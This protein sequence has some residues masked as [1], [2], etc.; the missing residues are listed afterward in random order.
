MDDKQHAAFTNGE[1]KIARTIG[2]A[3]TTFDGWATGKTLELVPDKK[4]VQEWRASDWP[5]NSLSTITLE[6]SPVAEGT[7][8]QFTQINVPSS[9]AK[10]IAKGW[11]EFYWEPLQDFFHE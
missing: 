11:K 1:A 2:G 4:I 9:F 5:E 6:L 10:S 3:F 7:V 8:V